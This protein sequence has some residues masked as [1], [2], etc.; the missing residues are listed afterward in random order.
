MQLSSLFLSATAL[1][2]QAVSAD[3]L[4][5]SFAL[6]EYGFAGVN[7]SNSGHVVFTH[8]KTGG[9]EDAIIHVTVPEGRIDQD[10]TG[11]PENGFKLYTVGPGKWALLSTRN[12][13][14]SV[15]DITEPFA[16]DEVDG[17]FVYKGPGSDYYHWVACLEEGEYRLH[18]VE[19][20]YG[21]DC[22]DIELIA[23]LV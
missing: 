11:D 15:T 9:W 10:A 4:L 12:D 14:A 3:Y 1:L 2:A 20:P 7:F 16:V 18:L 22:R 8:D 17:R 5:S 19:R 13:L 6:S 21:A 23:E